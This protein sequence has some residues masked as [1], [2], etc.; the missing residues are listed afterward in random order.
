MLRPRKT[1]SIDICYFAMVI[2]IDWKSINWQKSGFFGFVFQMINQLLIYMLYFVR[3]YQSILTHCFVIAI[4]IWSL[5][6]VTHG[7]NHPQTIIIHWLI[8]ASIH[9]TSSSQQ[10]L[11]KW[12]VKRKSKNKQRV[13]HTEKDNTTVI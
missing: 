12:T 6:R 5:R 3:W 11:R 4:E 10:Q 9:K 1:I 13:K 8:Q 2:E 7:S